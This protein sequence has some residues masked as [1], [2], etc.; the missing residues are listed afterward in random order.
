MVVK[1]ILGV[2]SENGTQKAL[3]TTP[4]DS[5]TVNDI[6]SYT[7]PFPGLYQPFMQKSREWR[8]TVI[9]ER[10]F[11]AAIYTDETAKD[12]WRL[13][14]T[15]DAV[16]FVEEDAPDGIGEKCVQFLKGAGLKFGAF[17]FIET[18]EGEVVF[19][20]CNPNGQYGW[21]EEA[22]GFPISRAIADELIK[23]ASRC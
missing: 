16:R 11:A 15:T 7:T 4:L 6:K 9:G 12:D 20:E 18:S 2:V 5:D 17:D 8:I 23:I 21:L 1:M 10:I 14:Q 3:Y 19:L 13:H 22:L